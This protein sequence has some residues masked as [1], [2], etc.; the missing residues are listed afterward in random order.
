MNGQH[1]LPDQVADLPPSGVDALLPGQS[2]HAAIARPEPKAL[3]HKLEGDYGNDQTRSE[4]AQRGQPGTPIQVRRGRIPRIAVTGANVRP[5]DQRT[6]CR[7]DADER[8]EANQAAHERTQRFMNG[9]DAIHLEQALAVRKPRSAVIL[10]CCGFWHGV[11]PGNVN[12]RSRLEPL[13]LHPL[14]QP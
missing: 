8:K 14:H 3:K 5:A 13:L 11:R 12:S 2:C 9:G 6:D 1:G 7:H 10:R 4:Q